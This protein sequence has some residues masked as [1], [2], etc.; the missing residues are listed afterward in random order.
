MCDK[1]ACIFSYEELGL[2]LE[3][4]SEISNNPKVVDILITLLYAATANGRIELLAPTNVNGLAAP[5]A[6][7]C[8]HGPAHRDTHNARAVCPAPSRCMS[9]MQPAKSTALRRMVPLTKLDWWG[10]PRVCQPGDRL[11]CDPFDLCLPCVHTDGL[12]EQIAKCGA[13]GR[14]GCG[15]QP[16]LAAQTQR[17]G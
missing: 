15:R 11:S 4:A 3:V 10:V 13:H 17:C 12:P 6:A 9:L 7:V 14:M 8:Y 5:H 1:Q 16:G 2:G